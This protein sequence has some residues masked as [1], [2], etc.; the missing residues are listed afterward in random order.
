MV[1]LERIHQMGFAE[2]DYKEISAIF[3]QYEEKTGTD[4]TG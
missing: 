2:R 1:E 4:R 3:K